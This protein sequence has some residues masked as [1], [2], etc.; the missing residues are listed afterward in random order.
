LVPRGHQQSLHADQSKTGHPD[1]LSE[2]DQRRQAPHP[3]ALNQAKTDGVVDVI[4]ELL[5][6]QLKG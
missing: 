2:L 6:D 5:A 3:D 1:G 4:E